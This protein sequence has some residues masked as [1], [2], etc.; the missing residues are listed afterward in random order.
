MMR[1]V[2]PL[3]PATSRRQIARF[4]AGLSLALLLLALLPATVPAQEPCLTDLERAEVSFD[5]GNWQ[6]TVDLLV[7]CLP[8]GFREARHQVRGYRLLALAYLRLGA[9]GQQVDEAIRKLLETDPGYRPDPALDPPDFI[10]RFN[11]VKA[12]FDAER[13][14]GRR[15]WLIISGAAVAGTVAA[16]LLLRDRGRS[17]L[18]EPPDPPALGSGR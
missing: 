3:A 15:K 16:I 2:Q 18:P 7:A 11:V 5:E 10:A 13:R 8:D 9:P 6:Q 4:A 17:E 1:S 12:Q 14:G